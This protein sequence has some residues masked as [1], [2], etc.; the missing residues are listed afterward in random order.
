[1]KLKPTPQDYFYGFAVIVGVTVI[2]LQ[3][4][5]LIIKTII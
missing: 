5:S 4:F 3:I 1:M 2:I